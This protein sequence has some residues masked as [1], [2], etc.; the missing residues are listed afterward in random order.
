MPSSGEVCFDNDYN[1]I[2]N[3]IYNI[4]IN[5]IIKIIYLNITCLVGKDKMKKIM[6]QKTIPKILT[7]L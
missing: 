7:I 5:T 2:Y 1:V 3:I 6:K 4:I